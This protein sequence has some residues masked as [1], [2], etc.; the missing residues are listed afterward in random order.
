M[1]LPYKVT[2]EMPRYKDSLGILKLCVSC[3]QEFGWIDTVNVGGNLHHRL[4]GDC[5]NIWIKSDWAKLFYKSDTA[6]ELTDKMFE[7]WLAEIK[8]IK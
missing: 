2:Q 4:C 5:Y 8:E 1:V 3:N 7:M 6:N